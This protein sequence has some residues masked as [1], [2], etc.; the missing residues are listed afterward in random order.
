MK[1]YAVYRGELESNYLTKDKKYLIQRWTSAK[2]F[3]IV[4]DD[5]EVINCC[6]KDCCHLNIRGGK[7]WNIGI[8]NEDKPI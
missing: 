1:H 2:F 5:G 8:I 6:T 7:N 4:D 3:E